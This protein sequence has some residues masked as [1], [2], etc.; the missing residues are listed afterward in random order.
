MTSKKLGIAFAGIV[1]LTLVIGCG[2]PTPEPTAAVATASPESPAPTE[3]PQEAPAIV[4]SD[5]CGREVV[6][7]APPQQIVVPGKATWM[8]AHALYMFP[9]ISGR[10]IAMEQRGPSVSDFIPLLD[11]TF[12]GK[13]HLEK[14]AAPEQIAPLK[15]DAILL[16]SYEYEKLGVPLEQ[17]GFPVVCID[18]E[19][20]AAFFADIA[21]M[22]QL[23][24]NEARASDIVDYYDEQLMLVK[25]ALEGLNDA[26]KPSVLVIQYD[27]GGEGIAFE[28]PS[29]S[30]LQTWM[31]ET[32]GGIP[33]WLDAAEGG[34]WTIV[35]FE[36]IAAW[37]ADKIFVIAFRD[38]AGALV[39]QLAAEPQWQA[40][41]AVQDG[42]FYGFPEDLYG[43]DLPDP[44]WILG[45]TWLAAKIHPDRFA[46]LDII[47]TMYD[48]YEQTYGMDKAA[49]DQHIIPAITG[50]IP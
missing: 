18:L 24:N 29:A 33:V 45:Q 46:D 9:G 47:E 12:A 44:R 6:F 14:D 36:Q 28:V 34:G 3:A 39:E 27:S 40:L 5:A 50:T 26:D 7:D 23:L 4:V 22:G 49:V 43:W 30:Y 42:E 20:P 17:L 19:T 11:P 13:P 16:K 25:Q 8:I 38:D 15:P 1:L 35:N 41:R 21:T 37:D 31:V 10:V 48:F 32:A 2:A